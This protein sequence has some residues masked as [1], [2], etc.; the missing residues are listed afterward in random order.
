ME[1]GSVRDVERCSK[2]R[3][4]KLEVGEGVSLRTTLHL[5]GQ[6]APLVPKLID[7]YSRGHP[8]NPKLFDLSSKSRLLGLELLDLGLE[9]RPLPPLLLECVLQARSPTL[10]VS[11]AILEIQNLLFESAT[12]TV[13]GYH[14]RAS[15][16]N[17]LQKMR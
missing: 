7:L 12:L 6:G 11:K 16:E 4:R 17:I 5:V 3:L 15:K 2:E 13:V 9:D 8:L 1:L 10:R 14:G